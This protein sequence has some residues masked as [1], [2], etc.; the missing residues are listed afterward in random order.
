M[1]SGGTL[2]VGVEDGDQRHLGQVEALAQQVDADQ[3]VELAHPQL[4]QQLDPAQGV[5]LGVQVAH[6]DAELEEVVGEVLGHLLGQRGD[7]D[8]LVALGRSRISCT[9]SSIWP[10][11]GLTTTS[12]SMRPVGRMICS[13]DAVARDRAR[14]APASPTGRP[15]GRSGRRTPP[16]SAA[17]CPSRWAAGSRG[18]RGSVCGTCRLRTS[19]PICGTVTCD[20]SMTSRKSSGK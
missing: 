1:R 15:S 5:H 8:P 11:V 17:G 14:T 6:A 3:H 9:R 16:T 20:S 12:G 2:L 10:L 7:E 13:T 4:A 18:R 19:P